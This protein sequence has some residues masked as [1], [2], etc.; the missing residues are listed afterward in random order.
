MNR[1]MARERGWQISR[2]TF[3]QASAGALSSGLFAAASPLRFGVVTD[4]HYADRPPAGTR[5][6][7]LALTKLR[8]CVDLMNAG[9]VDFLIELGDFKDQAETPSEES[10]LSFLRTVEDVFAGF[11][12]PRYHVLGNHDMDSITK[13]QF[14]SLVV[15]TG[16][17][18]SRTWY[19]FDR[20]G[21]H[22]VVLDANF[23]KDMAPYSQGN[24]DWRDTN[25]SPDQ[26][27]WVVRDLQGANRPTVVFSHQRLDEG[28]EPG[29]GN[30]VAVRQVLKESGKVILVMHGH[31][32][33]G[34][35]QKIDTLP[36]YTLA[37]SV[38][39]DDP[40]DNT[41]AWVQL[42]PAGGIEITG[43]RRARSCSLYGAGPAATDQPEAGRGNGLTP[44]RAPLA[45]ALRRC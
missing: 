30:R 37:A 45:S 17:D 22:F 39:K 4:I 12:G 23:R 36:Y 14:Q 27:D 16:I 15:N 20:G 18:R 9:K 26:L 40:S 24:F 38:E 11:R 25:V 2:R 21:V 28:K 1:D 10:T 29:I 34:D 41:C 43:Y 3:L 32:H 13:K 31:V 35:F 42:H 6:Y 44:R 33:E 5:F 8:A 19:S 7:R